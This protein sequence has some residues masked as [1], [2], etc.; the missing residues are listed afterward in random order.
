MSMRAAARLCERYGPG[1]LPKSENPAIGAGY[2]MATAALSAAALFVFVGGGFALV[3]GGLGRGQSI[4][5]FFA[6][7]GL[8]ATP[9]VVPAA[10][11]AGAL[12]W[13]TLPEGTP[14]Y[15]PVA[16]SVAIALTYVVATGLVAAGIIAAM[17]VRVLVV[18]GATFDI[19]DIIEVGGIWTFGALSFIFTCWLTLPVGALNG[20]IHERARESLTE[21]Q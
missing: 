18:S 2:A 1:R 15:G 20:Y 12:V 7:F 14:Y 19:T 21:Q 10:F 3:T 5:G 13:R 16:G 8:L 9:F 6:Y 4:G 17:I 11:L